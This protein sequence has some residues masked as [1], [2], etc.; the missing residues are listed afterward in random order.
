MVLTP[1]YYAFLMYQPFQGAT[2]LPVHVSSP[3]YAVGASKLPAVDVTAAK[4]ADGA[5]HVGLVNADPNQAAEV[6]LALGGAAAAD[7]GQVLTAAAMDSR[8]A[9]GA[10]EEVGRCRSAAPAGPAASC[11]CRMPAK[12]IVVLTIQ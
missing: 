7:P 3:D 2:A 4:G 10:P 12:S 11:A 9:F 1:T 6:E 8:N 5:I